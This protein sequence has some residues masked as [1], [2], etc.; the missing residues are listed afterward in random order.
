MQHGGVVQGGR[1]QPGEGRLP[2]ARV[3]VDAD[4]P[5]GTTG[6]RETAEA[7]GEGVNGGSR[8]DE[9]PVGRTARIRETF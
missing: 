8:R 9:G 1:Q 4:E 2:R 6:R 3:A 7:T 5:H